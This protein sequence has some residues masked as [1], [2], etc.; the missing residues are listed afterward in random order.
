MR[1]R[2][3]CVLGLE[4]SCLIPL[5]MEGNDACWNASWGVMNYQ[6][7]S[8]ANDVTL[9]RVSSTSAATARSSDSRTASLSRSSCNERTPAAFL[10]PSSTAD[11]TARVFPRYER[12]RHPHDS[13]LLPGLL[14]LWTRVEWWTD[15]LYRKLPRSAPAEPSRPSVPSL[16]PP[17]M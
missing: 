7:C 2:H 5:M 17:S 4:A 8:M 15:N 14:G 12:S 3:A 9:I 10:G 16:V 1:P 6:R 11:S 13:I